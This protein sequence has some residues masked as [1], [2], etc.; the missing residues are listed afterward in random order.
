MKA[1]ALTPYKNEGT[2]QWVDR[3]VPQLGP[4]QVRSGSRRRASTPWTA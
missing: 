1:Y 3:E 4:R 2:M